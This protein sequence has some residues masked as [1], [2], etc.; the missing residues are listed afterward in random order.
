VKYHLQRLG[1][2][3]HCRVASCLPFGSNN[4]CTGRRLQVPIPVLAVLDV[5]VGIVVASRLDRLMKTCER[6]A[7]SCIGKT[8]LSR[9]HCPSVIQSVL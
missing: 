5:T 7:V 9:S 2:I 8:K 6:M 4:E 3:S 1:P